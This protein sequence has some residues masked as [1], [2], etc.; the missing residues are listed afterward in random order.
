MSSEAQGTSTKSEAQGT[1][2]KSEAQM[3]SVKL[4]H[5]SDHNYE[6]PFIQPIFYIA[7]NMKHQLLKEQGNT[8]NEKMISDDMARV[9]TAR[10]HTEGVNTE[11]VNT[12]GDK[13]RGTRPVT[14]LEIASSCLSDT[15]F[16]L[17]YIMDRYATDYTFYYKGALFKL[18]TDKT[19]V[20]QYSIKVGHTEYTMSSVYEISFDEK[21]FILFEDF[22][23]TSIKYF[24]KFSDGDKIDKKKLKM[25][26]S[27]PDGEYFNPIG[28]RP[29]RSLESIFLPKEQKKTVVN[30][31]T[32]FLK[33]ETIQ[34]YEDFGINHKLTI[35]FEGV[36][37]TGKS[38][39]IAALASHFNMNIAI[40][41]FTPKMTDVG[42]MRSMRMFER[43]KH[44]NDGEGEEERDT[45]LVIE[46]MDC[47]FV[48]RK[49]ND[50][51]RNQVTFSGILNALDGVTTGGNQVVIMTTNHIENLD[52][53]L[54]RPGRVDH[55]LRFD[56]A[57]K[58]QI[59]EIFTV[60]TKNDP[61]IKPQNAAGT[62]GTNEEIIN[63][64]N[65][66]IIAQGTSSQGTSSQEFYEAVKALN[67]KITTSLLQQYL[68]KYANQSALI[69]ENVD[70][71]KTMYDACN[72]QS[73]AKLYS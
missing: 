70:E 69:V 56:Y 38:S 42:F 47:I 48:A 29:K 67:I 41:S 27:S 44:D 8:Y 45:L 35:L 15:D 68:L 53:A 2:T 16:N 46:D 19:D 21:D 24:K 18:K 65:R 23:K 66:K 5:V 11:G 61:T 26:I 73:E 7:M 33:P 4:E 22:I 14:K 1:S 31:I 57:T 13:A 32:N 59:K 9:H 54:I 64:V 34:Q 71:L 17:N 43:N 58:E 55:I 52:P 12:E 25:Y 60:Y 63:E 28:S 39:L 3:I 72:K 30:L 62:Q 10:V 40:I 51:N 6:K 37:G 36:P 50:E 49:S 20:K